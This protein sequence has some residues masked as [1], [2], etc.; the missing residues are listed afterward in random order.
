[1]KKAYVIFQ[2]RMKWTR[3]QS[4]MTFTETFVARTKAEAYSQVEPFRVASVV[5]GWHDSVG[6][7]SENL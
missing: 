2:I 1:M 5:C 3:N 7:G 6:V 4:V